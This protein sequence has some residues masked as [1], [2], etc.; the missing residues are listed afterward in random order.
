MGTIAAALLGVATIQIV[1]RLNKQ[2]QPSYTASDLYSTALAQVDKGNYKQAEAYL[3]QALL[4]EDDQTYR[5]Q[6]AVVKYRLKEYG[7]AVIQYHILIDRKQDVA[8]SWNGI[9]NAYR[10]W[11]TVDL[12]Q[13]DADIAQATHAY[14]SA[15]AADPGYVAAYSNLA[16]LLNSEGKHGE[17]LAIVDQ[18]IAATKQPELTT[19]RSQL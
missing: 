18:G 13:H 19:L 6:L 8:F 1:H 14:Q 11:A 10:D 2:A 4:K 5:N 15:I 9:G 17:A 12:A 7:D 3:E 16:L